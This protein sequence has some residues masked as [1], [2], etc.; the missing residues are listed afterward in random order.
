MEARALA[1]LLQ[2]AGAT[3]GPAGQAG[4]CGGEQRLAQCIDVG[5]RP[6]RTSGI[7]AAKGLD[8]LGFYR[9]AVFELVSVDPPNRPVLRPDVSRGGITRGCRSQLSDQL[10]RGTRPLFDG[11]GTLYRVQYLDHA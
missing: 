7:V 3:L 2:H 9:L 4:G 8:G 10:C 11:D 5:L 6:A 1:P